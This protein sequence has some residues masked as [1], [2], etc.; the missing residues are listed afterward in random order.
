MMKLGQ[1]WDP[2]NVIEKRKV[3]MVELTVMIRLL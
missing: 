1:P 3:M 2:V